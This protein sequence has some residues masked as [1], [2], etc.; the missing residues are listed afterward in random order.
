V[1]HRIQ[2]QQHYSVPTIKQTKKVSNID[3]KDILADV[4]GIKVSKHAKER[5]KERNIQIN[6]SQWKKITE[7]VNEAKHK[8]VKDSLVVMNDSTLLVSAENNTV[9]TAMNKNEATSRIF[10]NIDGTI[11]INE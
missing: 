3:F 9:I 2:L 8:G 6:E 11:L 7:K 10:T 5:L 4:Q 1:V